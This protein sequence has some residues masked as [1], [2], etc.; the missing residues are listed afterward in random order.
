MRRRNLALV[1]AVAVA[2]L[3]LGTVPVAA[4]PAAG[5]DPT[6]EAC[7]AFADYF[8]IEFLIA[9][10]SAFA[11]V[12]EKQDAEKAQDAIRDNFHLILSPKLEQVTQTLADGTDPSLRKLFKQQQQAFAKGVALLE[13]VGLSKDQIEKLS[14]VELTP[15]TDLQA[16][17]GDVDLD[18]KALAK[19][20]KK[21]GASADSIDITDATSKQKTAF[22]A[23]GASCGVF[24]VGVSCKVAVTNDEAVALLGA[25]V[26]VAK[27]DETCVY[28]AS[29]TTGASDDVELAVDVYDSA[30]AFDRLTKSTQNQS[31]PGVGDAAIA[32]DGFT[33]FS[34][35][36]TC[37]RTLFV[38]QGERTVV[39]AACN[40]DTPPSAEAL[41]GIA[42][43][44]LARVPA[45]E[46]A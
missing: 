31:V 11:Q 15:D 7:E 38:K 33:S 13:G 37:G 3:L 5:T 44:V 21:F 43:N 1:A 17:V 10:A 14:T 30:L 6:P 25:P 34:S 36:K 28:T 32:A 40:G 35:A 22:T 41:A 18:K 45:N 24:P 46:A 19:A 29:D 39:V 9:F 26:T 20:V 23:A 42:T 16:V 27:D 2:A 4:A 8:Q 12:G